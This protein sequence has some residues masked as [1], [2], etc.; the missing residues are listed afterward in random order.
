MYAKLMSKYPLIGIGLMMMAVWLL[1]MTD[2]G[3]LLD[4][5]E[6]LKPDSCRSALVMLNKRMPD[7][8]KT[9][10]IKL[11]MM[12][13]IAVD[14][15]TEL[16]SDPVKSRQLLYRELANSMVFISEN[17]LRD[18]LERVRFVVVS[19]HSDVLIVEGVSRGSDVVKLFGIDNDKLI[20]EHLKATVKVKE[21][22]K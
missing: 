15:P 21:S 4:R 12:V 9:S 7:S 14:I 1:S 16:L 2:L 22:A 11:D 19:L 17:T 3:K 5:K 20:Q 13:E 8:W 6:S 10:C 18:S